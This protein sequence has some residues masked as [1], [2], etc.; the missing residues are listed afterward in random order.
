MQTKCSICSIRIDV[1]QRESALGFDHHIT[2]EHPIWSKKQQTHSAHFQFLTR[3][4]LLFFFLSQIIYTTLCIYPQNQKMNTQQQKNLLQPRRKKEK[5][6][7]IFYFFLKKFELKP[8]K[9][10]NHTEISSQFIERLHFKTT[11]QK[12]TIM[13]VMSEKALR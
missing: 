10:K 5:C 11:I 12:M 2:Q 6:I 7:S 4:V 1:F 13:T 8:N 9:K 3:D